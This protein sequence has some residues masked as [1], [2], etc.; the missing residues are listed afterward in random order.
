MLTQTRDA[1]NA[2][3][4]AGFARKEF[5]VRTP[6][7]NRIGGWGDTQ[8][9]IWASTERQLELV[10]EMLAAGL[11]VELLIEP[12]GEKV[13]RPMVRLAIGPIGTLTTYKLKGKDNGNV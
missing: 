8:I 5:R 3:K 2:L 6:Y 1:V 4:A 13:W 11:D 10:A 7:D 9:V 12:I